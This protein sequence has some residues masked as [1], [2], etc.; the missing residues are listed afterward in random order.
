[1]K[2]AE[3]CSYL[4]SAIPLSF[5]ESYD[6]SGLQAGSAEMEILSALIAIDVTDE[7]LDEALNRGCNLI[8]SHHPVI[9]KPVKK[10]TGSTL[11]GR[12][13]TRSIKNDIAIY[14][15]HTNLD[16]LSNGVSRKM[17]E[18]LELH[19]INVL[20]PLKNRLLKLVTFIPEAHAGRV[21]DALFE[22]GVG[23]IGNYDRCGFSAAGTGSFR[24]GEKTH[25]FAGEPGSMHFEQEVRFETILFSYLKDKVIRA[26]LSAHPYEEVAY[27]LYPLENENT[28]EGLGCTG[29]LPEQMS[30]ADFL[31]HLS[32]VFDSGGIRYSRPA[33]KPVSKIALCGGSG[34]S[35]LGRAVSSGADAF[36]TADIKYHSF[37]DAG[38]RIMLVDIGHYESEK[39]TSEI[40]YS[41]IIKKFPKFAV[42]FSET[43]TN[44]INYL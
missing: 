40:L 4:D 28:E 19:D 37:F 2:L 20:E 5:Q 38:N 36:V 44:P 16:V 35:L 15:A 26:L 31:K 13:L 24:A 33:G 32:A 9:F 30:E 1:M 7:V 10:I 43:N 42:R 12:I 27:D 39:F 22:A 21:S 8:V 6:N 3:I 41:L 17:A 34:S 23:V 25:P 29:R 18:K 14:S 11:T